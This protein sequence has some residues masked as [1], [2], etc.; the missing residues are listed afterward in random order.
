MVTLLFQPGIQYGFSRYG[1]MLVSAA[2]EAP[3]ERPFL[4]FMGQRIFDPLGMRETVPDM[5]P[6]PE[7]IQ[8]EDFPPVHSF[9]RAVLRSGDGA[10]DDP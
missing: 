4:T 2:I 3:A 1:W 6:D 8:G 5:D 9:P 10:Q 7:T